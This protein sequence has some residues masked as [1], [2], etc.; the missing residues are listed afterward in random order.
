[1]S[2]KEYDIHFKKFYSDLFKFQSGAKKQLHCPGCSTKKRFIIDSDK[3]TYSCGPKNN[4]D[5]KCGVQYTIELPKYIHFRD[6]QK[7]YDEQINGSF[8]Y[9]KDNIFEY[10]L[11]SLSEKMDVKSDL[12]KQISSAKAATESLKRLIDDYIETN[13][14][15]GHLETLKTL[16]EKRYKNSIDKKKIMRDLLEEELSEEE[17]VDLRKKYAVLVKENEEFID[18]INVL[19][20][21]NTDYITIKKSSVKIHTKEST[22]KEST[23]KE[24]SKMVSKE[25][26]KSK[27]VSKKYSYEE[28]IQILTEFYK[29]VDTDK[30]EE[31]VKNLINR[32]RPKGK[33]IGTRIPTK[34][35]LN[36]CDKLSTKYVYHPL[37]INA[38]KDKFVKEE[39]DGSKVLVDSLSPDSPR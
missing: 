36:L 25:V 11:R 28:Q 32:R 19:R 5:T 33:P 16:S 37:R 14:L 30:S 2:E 1:M 39:D 24:S 38:E 18:L 29:K 34:P 35:W 27:E 4:K 13:N 7:V 23:D 6:L 10:D 3:L 15:N 20:E 9:Q 22:D 31:D 26:P 12:D 21:P 8:N 17:R